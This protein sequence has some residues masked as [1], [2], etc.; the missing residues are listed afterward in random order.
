MLQ[1]DPKTRITAA[2]ALDHLYFPA[3]WHSARDA[4]PPTR[5]L[6]PLDAFHN[7][8]GQTTPGLQQL[9]Q[10]EVVHMPRR[11]PGVHAELGS[12]RAMGQGPST[13]PPQMLGVKYAAGSGSLLPNASTPP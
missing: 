5:D 2:D 9:Q 7:P 1:Y 6:A 11:P 8:Q 12:F 3:R 4:T 13:G 10:P